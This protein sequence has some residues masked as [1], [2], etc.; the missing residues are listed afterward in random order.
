MTRKAIAVAAAFLIAAIGSAASRVDQ[1]KADAAR[2]PTAAT[3]ILV[4]HAEKSTAPTDAM[5]PDLCPE[6]RVRAEALTVALADCSLDAILVTDRRR[7]QQTAEPIAKH[8][9][10]TPR[11]MAAN[12]PPEEVAAAALESGECVLIVGHSNTI[13]AIIEALG[14]PVGVTIEEN[15]YEN[16]F[17]FTTRP[18]RDPSLVRARYGPRVTEPPCAP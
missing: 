16:L 14:G 3:I 7:T 18:G 8:R 11:V 10:L 1:P 6:G 9:A 13:P 12:T 15:D 17:V 4:R 5:G 2:V